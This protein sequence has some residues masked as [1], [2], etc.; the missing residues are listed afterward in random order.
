MFV[1]LLLVSSWMWFGVYCLFIWL[2]VTCVV[3]SLVATFNVVVLGGC[4]RVVQLWGGRVMF[5]EVVWF[6]VVLK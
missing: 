6:G 3:V 1:L 5:G 2:D 4:V